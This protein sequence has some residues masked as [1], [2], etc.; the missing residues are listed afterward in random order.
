MFWQCFHYP[1]CPD[2]DARLRTDRR[3][4]RLTLRILSELALW[5]EQSSCDRS[6]HASN[7]QMARAELLQDVLVS[8]V[9]VCVCAL[10]ISEQATVMTSIHSE[11]LK[12]ASLGKNETACFVYHMDEA[13]TK[14]VVYWEKARLLVKLDPC[15]GTP[16]LKVSG[17]LSASARVYGCPSDG[18]H[19]NWE[20]QSEL[21]RNDLRA[22][23]EPVPA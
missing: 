12:S 19:V 4:R 6:N 7:P 10:P 8:V 2:C 20:F 18:H 3:A 21:A 13:T 22:R 11:E 16:H 14:Q 15:S 1:P 17:P 9:L 5:E 23:N